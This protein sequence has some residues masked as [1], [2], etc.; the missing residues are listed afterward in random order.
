MLNTHGEQVVD[1]IVLLGN[2]IGKVGSVDICRLT[3][4]INDVPCIFLVGGLTDHVEGLAELFHGI[5]AVLIIGCNLGRGADIDL[6][7]IQVHGLVHLLDLVRIVVCLG[8]CRR[9]RSLV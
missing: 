5:D 1:R 6:T 9:S 4:V 3:V 7:C 2:G 8:L